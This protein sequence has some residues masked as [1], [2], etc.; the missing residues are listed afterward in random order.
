MKVSVTHYNNALIPTGSLFLADVAT[1]KGCSQYSHSADKDETPF[2]TS[3]AKKGY[4]LR[5]PGVPVFVGR[6]RVISYSVTITFSES[7]LKSCLS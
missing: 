3:H 7:L 5:L 6:V 1:H 2:N 4:S